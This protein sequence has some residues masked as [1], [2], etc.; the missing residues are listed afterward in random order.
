[1]NFFAEC[2]IIELK[3]FLGENEM[4]LFVNCCPRENSR[5]ERL[6]GKLLEKLGE[7]VEVNPEKEGLVPLDRERLDYRTAL[8]ER[9]DFSDDIFRYAKQFAG[10]DTIVIAAPFWDL[11]FPSVL[12]IYIENIYVTGIVS[13]YDE[14]GAPKGLCKARKLYYVTTAGG[15]YDGRFS[16]DYLKALAEDYFGIEET[17]LI[18]AEK[19]DIFGNNPEEILAESMKFYGID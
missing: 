11:S 3:N 7:F 5:T 19:L 18:K 8:V 9:G 4:I 1:M 17:V 16:F 6:A 10:A 14:N 12:K 15:D 2:V 13:K